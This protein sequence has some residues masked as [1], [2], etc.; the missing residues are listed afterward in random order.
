MKACTRV[1]FSIPAATRPFRS[2]WIPKTAPRA[3]AWFRPAPPP[4]RAEAWERRDGDKSV[5]GG[6]GVLN[7]VKAVNEV[8]APKVIGMDAA[9]QRALDDLMIELDGTP[10]KGKLGV[11]A[12]LGVSWLLC[13]LPPESRRPAAVPLHRRHQRPHPAGPGT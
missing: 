7:A 13:T 5:Y 3:W 4:V 11:N 10:N 1:R 2:F 9:D 8:I 12:I 6:K